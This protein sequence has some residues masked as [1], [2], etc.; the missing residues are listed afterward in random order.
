MAPEIQYILEHAEC[1]M[2]IVEN[3]AQLEKVISIKKS[4]KRLK[5]LIVLDPGFARADRTAANKLAKSAGVKL[6]SFGEVQEQ[7][8]EYAGK[9]PGFLEEEIPRG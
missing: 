9:H 4:L 1:T 2:C 3:Q 8:R 5:T 6:F 7:G